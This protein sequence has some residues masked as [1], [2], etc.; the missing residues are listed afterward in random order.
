ML[1]GKDLY[2]SIAGT[3]CLGDDEGFFH[4]CPGG[5]F[6][7]LDLSVVPGRRTSVALYYEESTLRKAYSSSKDAKAF[8]TVQK[9]DTSP[10]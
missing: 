2:D 10:R 5:I 7:V 9:Y 4:L 8:D 1:N 3:A 6:D